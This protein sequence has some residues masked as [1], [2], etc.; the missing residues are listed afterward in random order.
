MSA[1]MVVNGR[2][3]EQRRLVTTVVQVPCMYELRSR[4]A[5]GMIACYVAVSYQASAIMTI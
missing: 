1:E 4:V 3:I 5:V 2:P